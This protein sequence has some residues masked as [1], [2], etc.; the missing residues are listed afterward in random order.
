M[1][2]APAEASGLLVTAIRDPDPVLFIEHRSLYAMRGPVPEPIEPIPF[3]KARLIQEGTDV[4]VVAWSAMV[5]VAQGAAE[6]LAADGVSVEVIDPRTLVPFDLEAIVESVDKTGRL[7][8]VH[9]AVRRSGFGAEIAASISDSRAFDSLLG[10]IVRVANP[11]V[12][13][14]HSAALH[15]HALPTMEDVIAAVHRIKEYG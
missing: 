2:S 1:P 12:P 8:I 6:R 9:E 14:P 10:P 11:G 5:P 13:V 3:G 7:V 15:K 4:T